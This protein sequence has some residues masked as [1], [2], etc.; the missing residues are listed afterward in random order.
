MLQFNSNLNHNGHCSNKCLPPKSA[1]KR[2]EEHLPAHATPN[3]R[4]ILYPSRLTQEKPRISH[5]EQVSPRLIW[6]CA[7]KLVLKQAHDFFAQQPSPLDENSA[8]KFFFLN[9]R[10][11]PRSP[12]FGSN[13]AKIQL[14]KWS[15]HLWVNM[16]ANTYISRCIQV[17][18]SV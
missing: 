10:A 12:R 8:T 18:P 5:C 1:Q 14:G 11:H 13:S 3:P 7:A 4:D 17:S 16:K 9:F 15:L 6:R 2:H